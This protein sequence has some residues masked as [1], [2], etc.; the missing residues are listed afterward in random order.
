[1]D[2]RLLIDQQ[3]VV[4]KLLQLHSI[5]MCISDA[6]CPVRGEIQNIP[7]NKRRNVSGLLWCDVIERDAIHIVQDERRAELIAEITDLDV[8]QRDAFRMPDKETIGR[9]LPKHRWLGIVC[10]SL[11]WLQISQ[12][13]F[14]P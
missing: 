6:P 14:A 4:S 9:Q 3:A 7:E 12:L 2:S 11:R 13:S 10:L 8:A 5:K 1:P